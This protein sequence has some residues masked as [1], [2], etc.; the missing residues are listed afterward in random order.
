M[1]ACCR[2]PLFQ[3]RTRT[4]C[5]CRDRQLVER[6][7]RGSAPLAVPAPRPPRRSAP[8]SRQDRWGA[9]AASAC[10]SPTCP[11]DRDGR[12]AYEE[13]ASPDPGR[14][15]ALGLSRPVPVPRRPP[16]PWQPPPAAR[17]TARTIECAFL[18]LRQLESRSH[19]P[20]NDVDNRRATDLASECAESV[21]RR[22][23]RVNGSLRYLDPCGTY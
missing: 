17:S 12:Q 10:E 16:V 4:D 21:F 8:A 9:R 19:L 1:S 11:A 13:V 15:L 14:Q 6:D 18:T 2:A 3:S 5:R 20:A 7:R 23:C 22:C